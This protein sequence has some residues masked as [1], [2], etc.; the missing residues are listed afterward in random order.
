MTATRALRVLSGCE[1]TNP[2]AQRCRVD[3]LWPLMESAAVAATSR[4]RA[5][6]AGDTDVLK[7]NKQDAARTQRR[8]VGAALIAFALGFAA[9]AGAA[10]SGSTGTMPQGH[11]PMGKPPATTTQKQ[12][13]TKPT[14]L[15]DINSASRAELKTL[16][17]IGDA[18][19]AR[20]IAAR[21]YLSKAELV[22]KNVL[23][24]GVYVALKNQIIAK[25]A[26][27]KPVAKK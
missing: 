20:I 18:E 21:P 27:N 17:G 23:P 9:A 15:V 5:F 11:P 14:K 6:F 2:A 16:Q 13:A 26:T 1:T 3:F 8:V 22:S 10:D 24:E 12:A 4:R 19:A 25:Q 7:T